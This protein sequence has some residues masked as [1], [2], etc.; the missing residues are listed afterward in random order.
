MKYGQIFLLILFYSTFLTA[1]KKDSIAYPDTAYLKDNIYRIDNGNNT[2]WGFYEMETKNWLTEPIY[3]S[4][5]YRYRAGLELKYYEIKEKGK[6]GLLKSDRSVW[7][8]AIYDKVN[9]DFNVNPHRIFIQKNGK[10]GILNKDGS[11]WLEPIY[12]DIYFNGSYFKVKKIDKW[13]IL[14]YEG[15]EFVPICY[16]TV[17]EHPVAEMSL[18][19]SSSNGYWSVFAWV[20]KTYNPC[21]P[22]ENFLYNRIEYFNEFFMVNKNGKWGLADKTGKIIMDIKYEDMK[23]FVFTYLRILKVKE[24]GKY[25][26]LKIDSLGNSAIVADI[27]YDEIAVDETNYKIKAR[28]GTKRDYI[29]E[30]QPYFEMVYED[31]FF[32]DD[33]K[34]FSIKKGKKWGLAKENKEVFVQPNYDKILFIDAKTY[35]VQKS[36]K[37]GVI[38]SR[39]ETIIPVEFSEFD[40]RPDQGMFFASK[41]GKWGIVSLRSGIVLPAVYDNVMIL[42]NRSFLVENKGLIGVVGPGGKVIVPLEYSTYYYKPDDSVVRLKHSSGREYKYR[43]K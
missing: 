43:I 38:N 20:Q 37:W 31:V 12:D 14:N 30:T 29:Y 25:G 11:T 40:Y 1:Q 8:P 9:Y 17:Y 21:I 15:K 13:G 27:K 5:V 36:G 22:T 18:I 16:E 2:Q 42:P 3:D 4:V 6:W 34:I 32:S 35:M 41:K 24:N 23:P 33:Y 26:L 19:R 28:L 7:I 10:Y 39:D